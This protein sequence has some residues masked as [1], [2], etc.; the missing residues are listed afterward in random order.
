M[1]ADRGEPID[2][3]VT[4]KPVDGKTK[5]LSTIPETVY[6]SP[7]RGADWLHRIIVEIRSDRVVVAVVSLRAAHRDQQG[8]GAARRLRDLQ[9]LT[10]T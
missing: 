4:V 2:L 3:T 7:T 8:D 6:L 9:H 5:T 10:T 1:R